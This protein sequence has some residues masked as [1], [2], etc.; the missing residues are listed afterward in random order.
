MSFIQTLEDA[1][2]DVYVPFHM[3]RALDTIRFGKLG[4]MCCIKIRLAPISLCA[5]VSRW[6]IM[7]LFVLG[8]VGLVWL[9]VTCWHRLGV[10]CGDFCEGVPGVWGSL[11]VL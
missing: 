10:L 1:R 5:D 8:D 7:S 11:R 2:L 9:G 6:Y 4:K 3:C